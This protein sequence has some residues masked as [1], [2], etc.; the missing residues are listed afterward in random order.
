VLG[1]EVEGGV[2]KRRKGASIF[3]DGHIEAIDEFECGK[4][5]EGIVGDIAKEVDLVGC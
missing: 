4:E 1:Y 2:E 3:E 5:V